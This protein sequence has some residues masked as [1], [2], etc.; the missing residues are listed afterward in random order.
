MEG[1]FRI[2]WC[3]P[4]I[5]PPAIQAFTGCCLSDYSLGGI[6]IL[7]G[8]IILTTV[9]QTLGHHILGSCSL[10]GYSYTY[11]GCSSGSWSFPPNYCLGYYRGEAS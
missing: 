7:G 1:D 4:S 8:V 11:L 9:L 10:G 3:T 2:S 5:H 6:I